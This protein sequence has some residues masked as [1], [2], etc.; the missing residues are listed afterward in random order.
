ML[1]EKQLKD[2]SYEIDEFLVK[3]SHKYT[4]SNLSLSAVILARLIRATET[5][6]ESN[7]F[8][9]IMTSALQSRREQP[10]IQ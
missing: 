10:T 7:D 2:L 4:V 1:N 9:T 3:C 5:Y 8:E 6:G